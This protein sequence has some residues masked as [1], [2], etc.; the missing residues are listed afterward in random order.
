MSN[1]VN[2]TRNFVLLIPLINEVVHVVVAEVSGSGNKTTFADSVTIDSD[3]N[4]RT[5]T[6]IQVE[7]IAG[8][9]T[10]S[11]IGSLNHDNVRFILR[12]EFIRHEDAMISRSASHVSQ[13]NLPFA[14]LPIVDGINI[15]SKGVVVNTPYII[16]VI[17]S[18]GGVIDMSIQLNQSSIANNSITRNHDGRIIEHEEC[19]NQ[20]CI[21]RD[22]ACN[23]IDTSNTI[24]IRAGSLRHHGDRIEVC[25]RNSNAVFVPNEAVS[26]RTNC[27]EGSLSAEA[28]CII[29]TCKCQVSYMQCININIDGVEA[30]ASTRGGG[31][32]GSHLIPTFLSRRSSHLAAARHCVTIGIN[33]SV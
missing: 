29:R 23:G 14:S 9:N 12:S 24:S 19:R 31:S 22:T 3:S 11:F 10:T 2:Y 8:C 18:I 16:E 4:C 28:N 13:D 17:M 7:Q 25:T 1:S 15:R 26:A 27:L 32:G 21:F 6:N 33:P 5:C 20:D 30:A